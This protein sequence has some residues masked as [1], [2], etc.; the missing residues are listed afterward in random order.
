MASDSGLSRFQTK[1]P[2]PWFA[3]LSFLHKALAAFA[4]SAIIFLSGGAL[5]WFVTRQYIPRM[6]LMVAGAAVSSAVGAL[7]FVTLTEIQ[8][9]YQELIDRLTRIAELNHHIRNALQ[10]IA[11]NNAQ[12]ERTGPSI[13]QVNLAISRIE[14]V[15]REVSDALGEHPGS[16]TIAV[17]RVDRK[18]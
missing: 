5:D 17:G 10:V 9:R 6:S 7:G 18:P 11:Y 12:P 4:V 2:P 16:S 3:K 14:V 1:H 15:L 13:Q 8:K